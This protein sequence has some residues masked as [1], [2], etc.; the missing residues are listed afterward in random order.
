MMK[1]MMR[2]LSRSTES[3]LAFCEGA[4]GEVVI[5]CGYL[6]RT[7]ASI[8]ARPTATNPISMHRLHLSCL[9]CL[10]LTPASLPAQ[11]SSIDWDSLAKESQSVLVDYL[12][13]NTTNPPGNEILG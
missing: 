5:E 1:T 12:R 8:N 11:S 10:L 7:F 4:Y 13:I 6:M 9:A 3:I 2:P